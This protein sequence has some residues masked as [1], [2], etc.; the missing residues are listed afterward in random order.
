MS[1][2]DVRPKAVSRIISLV[3]SATE[4][5]YFL[6][7]EEL[8]SG[9]T[10][11]CNY[12]EKASFKDKVGTFAHPQ[13][14]KILALQP[15]IVLADPALHNRL[16][17]EL[18]N[19]KIS[20]LAA[21]P[22]NIEDVFA[23]MNNLGEITQREITVQPIVGQLK[24]RVAKLRSKSALR[25]PR[26]FRLMNTDPFF[27]PGPKSFQYDALKIA[28]AHL[29]DFQSDAPYVK[30]TWDQIKEFDPE[31]I[32]FCG[33]EKEQPKPL[34]CKGCSAKNPVCQRTVDDIVTEEWRGI[35]AVRK[36]NLYP[37]SCATICRPG[38]RL[39][40]GIEKLHRLLQTI[41]S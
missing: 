36:N 14:S 15:D 3:P 25:R 40:D 4:I 9:V 18:Q 38:P 11:H 8:V 13:L 41:N 10:E 39:I 12:P 22:V 34:R 6:G 32:L 35:T 37:I 7:L 29:M 24:E 27:T 20:I 28:G 16:I 21:T 30:V 31:V 33:V 1:I 5:L 23:L 19:N 26:V 2:H 17:E